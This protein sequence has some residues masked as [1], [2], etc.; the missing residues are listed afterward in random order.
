MRNCF[1][2][3]LAI[4]FLA[5]CRSSVTQPK[6]TSD[7]TGSNLFGK[8]NWVQT[9]GAW[10]GTKKPD[11]IGSAYYVITADS[12]IYF[13]SPLSSWHSR[14]T[15][16]RGHSYVMGDTEQFIYLLDTAA[17]Y[18]PEAVVQRGDSLTI[19]QDVM[20]GYDELYIRSK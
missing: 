16:R 17:F 5:G 13:H 3:A 2:L 14:F 19:N 6:S 20:D 8:W 18:T 4:V 15:L 11:S 9:Q 7:S 12:T 10:V 1:L